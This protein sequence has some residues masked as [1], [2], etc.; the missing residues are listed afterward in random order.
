LAGQESINGNISQDPLFCDPEADD[1]TLQEGSPCY[2][3]LPEGC[4]EGAIGAFGIGCDAP[5]S[6]PEPPIE[7]EVRETTWGSI[8]AEFR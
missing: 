7:G 3:P 8:K 6:V 2:T 5:S 4:G 1:Y